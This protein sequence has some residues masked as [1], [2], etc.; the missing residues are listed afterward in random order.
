MPLL[1]LALALGCPP[2]THDSAAPADTDPGHACLEAGADC[3]L[4]DT[5]AA[6]GLWLGAAVPTDP[7]DDRQAAVAAH[8]SSI[9]AENAMK[10]GAL[11]P[12]LGHCDYD[13]ADAMVDLAEQHGLRVRG[14]TLV[15]GQHP[16]HGHPGDLAALT[17][18]AE[19]PYTFMQQ[20]ITDHITATV[21]RYRGRVESWDVVN[22]PL[23]PLGSTLDES[24]FFEAMGADYLA[25]A[26]EAAHAADPDARL[27]VNEYV[28]ADYGG[29]KARAFVALLAELLAQGA[30][31]HGAGIQAHV[32]V[33]V[34]DPDALGGLI[35]DLAALGLDVE[36]T[37]LDVAKLALRADLD[38][39]ADLYQA[40][41]EVYEILTAACLAEPRCTGL[42]T[43]G[44]DDGHTWLDTTS[45]YDAMAPNEPLLLDAEFQPKPAHEAVRAT[46][47][48]GP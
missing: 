14:H 28:I 15:W 46:L 12:T 32:F 17:A 38:D 48:R 26:L 4:A 36:L 42:S 6:R 11:C 25:W 43:W 8:F 24:V 41:A 13:Q 40:Q 29:D 2:P 21:G 37:E 39:G 23:A 5:A 1:L 18:A 35:H 33:E 31:L 10:W 16:G 34:P 20:A 44:I 7:S 27:F 47:I 19:D 30:P 9:T 3:S 22:E 45:P